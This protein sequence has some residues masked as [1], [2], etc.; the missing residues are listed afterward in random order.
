MP[1]RGERGDELPAWVASKEKRLEKIRE[2]RAALEKEAA[3]AAEE[4]SA[5]FKRGGG[6]GSGGETAKPKAKAQRNFTAHN[7][8]KLAKTA[9]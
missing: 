4:K 7:L 1:H 8:L 5:E 9:R 2:A 6:G 3:D